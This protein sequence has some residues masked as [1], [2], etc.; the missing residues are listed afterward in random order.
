M[1]SNSEFKFSITIHNEIIVTSKRYC[2]P[3]VRRALLIHCRIETS[4]L[5]ELLIYS[6]EPDTPWDMHPALLRLPYSTVL[7]KH[8]G[9]HSHRH[10][11]TVL[12]GCFPWNDQLAQTHTWVNREGSP[13]S[14]HIWV[15]FPFHMC[16]YLPCMCS[17]SLPLI[18]HSRGVLSPTN[19][20]LSHTNME[21]I[22]HGKPYI[23]QYP[24]YR[25]P[26]TQNMGLGLKQPATV[27]PTLKWVESWPYK[28][29]LQSPNDEEA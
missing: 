8:Y 25:L 14:Q 3:A 6:H 17:C 22:P 15:L 9:W 21:E 2:K 23:S 5:Q 4:L 26:L 29:D 28:L 24:H 19:T 7:P 13:S 20:V 18:N 16:C 10:W 12:W 1:I 11:H 27:S